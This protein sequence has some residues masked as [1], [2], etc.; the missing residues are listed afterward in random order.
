MKKII[1][2]LAILAV[3]G[4]GIYLTQEKSVEYVAPITV[5]TTPI[6]EIDNVSE[7]QKQINEANRLLNEEEK[8]LLTQ[9][10]DIEA[11]LENIRKV[12]LSFSQAPKQV[13]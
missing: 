7:A 13:E 6:I 2:G 1:I 9:K 4:I 5:V 8:E 12:R 10:A 3:A 11:K